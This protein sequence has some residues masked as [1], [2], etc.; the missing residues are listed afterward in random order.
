MEDVTDTVFR[1]MVEHLGGPEVYF[2]E[3]VRARDILIPKNKFASA[4]ARYDPAELC[5]PLV[6]QVWGNE[7]EKFYQAAELLKNRGFSGIDI[8][9]GCPQPRV[10]AGGNGAALIRDPVLARELV[11]AAREGAP[12]L[13]VSVKTRIGF[14]K[15][16]TEDWLGFLLELDLPALT[17][18]GRV[19]SQGY[20]GRADWAEIAKAV[21]LRDTLKRNTMIIGNGDLFTGPDFR[22]RW[23]ESGVDGLM[24]GRGILQDPGLFRAWPSGP[25]QG[26]QPWESFSL[27]P[28]EQ[29]LDLLL[30]HLAAHERVWG[31]EKGYGILKKFFKMYASDFPGYETLR[32][33]LMKTRCPEETRAVLEAWKGSRP[34]SKGSDQGPGSLLQP[35]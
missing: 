17:V 5:K 32:L 7:P 3:F 15:P 33:D 11:L 34:G 9:M 13:P 30:H 25:R 28:E 21:L 4:H 6:A 1:R 27:W 18:H 29:K 35:F 12:G 14:A 19:Q 10:V 8:N 31:E 16:A 20:S 26:H 2:T 24:V 22:R 23:E